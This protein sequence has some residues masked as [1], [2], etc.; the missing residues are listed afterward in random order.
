MGIM[1]VYL[2]TWDLNKEK[3]NYNAARD[4]FLTHL[5]RYTNKKDPGLD[6]VRFVSTTWSARQIMDDLH[7]KMDDNDTLF[8]TKLVSSDHQ[9]WL[10]K[11]TWE[12]IDER[13]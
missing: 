7:T 12:W 1:A 6:S 3:P 10:S 11:T 5:D 13:L 9:G 2:V 8:V 4:A